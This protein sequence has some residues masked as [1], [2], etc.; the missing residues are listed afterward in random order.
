VGVL[1]ALNR[2]IKQQQDG[3]TFLGMIQT[4][5]AINPGNSGGPLINAH[6]EIIGINTF[7]FTESGGSIGLGFAVPIERAR[8]II[9]DVREYGRYRR[10]YWGMGIQQITA[11]I[12][13]A[14]S[15]DDPHGFLVREV[16]PEA[17]AW[18]AGLRVYDVLR[19]IDGVAVRDKDTVDRIIYEAKVGS[20][21][22]VT[23]EREG[24]PMESVIVLEEAPKR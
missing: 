8:W 22:T 10:P 11:P 16:T 21:L 18:K 14:L 12:A 1:S 7:I 23:F 3:Q 24:E 15:L 17:P 19:G 6:G 4:D 5:A 2:D 20:E 9:R 13:Q